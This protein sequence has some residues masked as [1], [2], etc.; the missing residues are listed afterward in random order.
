MRAIRS[1]FVAA[2]AFSV[3]GFAIGCDRPPLRLSRMG[4][5]FVVDVQTLGE[6]QT[7]IAR[8]RLTRGQEI[9]WEATARERAAQLH[10][11]GLRIGSN[12]GVPQECAGGHRSACDRP[13]ASEG[14]VVLTPAGDGAFRI[15][16]GANYELEV[17]GSTSPWSRVAVR[18]SP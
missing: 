18:L 9:V 15:D 6:Y 13:R 17:W 1:T 3:G 7:S 5:T 10:T 14:F 12:P 2:L 16:P 4:D 11:F 8:I